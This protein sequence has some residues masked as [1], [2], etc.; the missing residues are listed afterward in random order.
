MKLFFVLSLFLWL[1]QVCGQTNNNPIAV[2]FDHQGDR[3]QGWYYRATGM[4]P[5]P[6]VILLQGSVGRDGDLF[7]LGA[8]LSEHGI[9]AMTYG[10]PGCWRSEGL[11]TDKAVL[12]SIQSAIEFVKSTSSVQTFGTDTT[13][14]I[15]LGYS[16]GG[17]MAMI[18]A[19]HDRKVRKVISIMGSDWCVQAIKL[20]DD[21]A[22]RSNLETRIDNLLASGRVVRATSGKEYIESMIRNKAEYDLKNYSKELAEKELLFIVGWLDTDAPMEDHFLPLYRQLTS[23]GGRDI[24]ISAFHTNHNLDNAENEISD[25]IVSWLKEKD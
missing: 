17:G 1:T 18:G 14:I 9:N 8:D 22:Y 20:E 10:Y 12:S 19:V 23:D 3:L 7:G 11:K 16:Y 24:T 25:A 6:T 4:G 13:D 15:L 21:P 2:N 5:F